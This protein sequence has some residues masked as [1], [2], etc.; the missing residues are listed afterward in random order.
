LAEAAQFQQQVASEIRTY[1]QGVARYLTTLNAMKERHEKLGEGI[2]HL[3]RSLAET[4][5]PVTSRPAPSGKFKDCF[6]LNLDGEKER[7][8]A[9]LNKR[10]R[11]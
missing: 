11:S 5:P 7:L 1:D 4:A 2:K 10:S 6:P 3:D 8:I 9:S